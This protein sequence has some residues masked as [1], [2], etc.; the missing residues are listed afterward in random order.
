MFAGY[1]HVVLVLFLRHPPSWVRHTEC[2]IQSAYDLLGAINGS[3]K[4]PWYR[5]LTRYFMWHIVSQDN[6]LTIP[7]AGVEFK[8][9][10]QAY[11]RWPG[12][13]YQRGFE[14]TLIGAVHGHS[15]KSNIDYGTPDERDTMTT[16]VW[17]GS[18][19][20][21]YKTRE[22]GLNVVLDMKAL[23]VDLDQG[24]Q[25]ACLTLARAG[26]WELPVP[27]YRVA[28]HTLDVKNG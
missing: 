12:M 2:G 27:S 26:Q 19:Q 25:R 28:M 11:C 7:E 6:F 18:S 8:A 16:N 10:F 13:V 24:V 9:R 5:R 17:P 14:P 3:M 4:K 23:V 21:G 20:P 15:R 22:K 1:F